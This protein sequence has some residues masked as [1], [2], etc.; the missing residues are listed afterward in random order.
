MEES[1]G[2]DGVE[3]ERFVGGFDLVVVFVLE[4]HVLGWLLSEDVA[5][6]DGDGV[7]YVDRVN[8]GLVVVID[9]PKAGSVFVFEIG[10]A[11]VLVL[12][13]V[14]FPVVNAAVLVLC[15]LVLLCG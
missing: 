11:F 6:V 13:Q 9:S 12:L 7:K 3:V 1:V 15:F 4:W 10:V 8:G 14:A 2:R 5:P